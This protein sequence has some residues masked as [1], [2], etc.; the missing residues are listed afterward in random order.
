MRYCNPWSNRHNTETHTTFYNQQPTKTMQRFFTLSIFAFLFLALVGCD[1]TDANLDSADADATE[2]AAESVVI[3][4]SEET[5][6]MADQ[7][8][9]AI[10]VANGAS[11][12]AEG[13]VEWTY[14]ETRQ[15]WVGTLDMSRT[16]EGGRTG[17]IHRVYERQFLDD[18]TPQ[19]D[20]DGADT[21]IFRIIEGSGGFTGPNVTHTLESLTGEWTITDIDTDVLSIVGSYAREGLDEVN[22]N[23]VSRTLDHEM[24]ANVDV[25]VPKDQTARAAT[26]TATGTYHALRTAIRNGQERTTEIDITFTATFDN[27]EVTIETSGERFFGNLRLGVLVR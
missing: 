23:N 12:T 26:G 25:T 17:E 10:A 9:D 1:T 2:D 7:L 4:L 13:P 27:G 22:R 15:L 3:A 14:D 19:Q 18:G 11:K 6:G 21:I 24:T 20:R 16:G 5:G 8:N